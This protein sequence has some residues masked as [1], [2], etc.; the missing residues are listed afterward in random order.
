MILANKS[1]LYS[2]YKKVGSGKSL[3]KGTQ[4]TRSLLV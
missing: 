2:R 4:V 3:R 1:Q